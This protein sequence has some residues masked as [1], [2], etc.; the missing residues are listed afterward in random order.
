MTVDVS[1]TSAETYNL[2]NM[3]R[4]WIEGTSSSETSY[5]S[6]T[7]NNYNGANSWGTGGAANTTSDRYSTNL[8]NAGSTTFSALGSKTV[9][10]NSDGIQVIQGWI[11]GTVTNY[12]LTMQNYSTVSGSEYLEIA[13]TENTN[14]P[15]PKLNI[16]YCY[17]VIPTTI[18]IVAS[19]G[20]HGT[21]TPSGPLTLDYLDDQTY[22]INATT[23]GYHIADVLVDGTSVGPVST[24]TF[25][26]VE[27]DHTITAT[28]AID[29]FTLNYAAGTGGNLTGNISQV[30]DYNGSG[31]P[32]TAVP[33]TGYH[34]VNWSDGSTANPRT[35][36]NVTAN[37]SVT[38]NFA[39]NTYTLTYAAGAGGTLTGSTTQTV[40]YNGSGTAVTA[41]PNTGYHF[42]NWSDGSTANPRTDTNVTANR[43]RHRQLRYQHLH[44]QLC[45]RNRW[46]P[47]RKYLADRELRR[48]WLAVTAVPNT[49]YHFVSWSDGSTANP[50]TDTNVTANVN[51]TAN[52]AI[53]T[54]TLNYTAGTG[55][56]LTG[57]AS[58]NVNY[59][60]DGTP[61]TAV[62]S[63]GYH[64]VSWSDGS[65]DNPRTD[66]NITSDL[67][68]TANFAINTFTLNYTAGENGSLTGETSQIVNYGADGSQV[69]AVPEHRL[70][71]RQLVRRLHSQPPHGYQCHREY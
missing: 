40:N 8:W 37:R 56:S 26:N 65:T 70:P 63:T 48:E 33:N 71:L 7:W 53:D 12:G 19:A 35:D 39:I 51:V 18:S 66:E 50:R 20:E 67:N 34:F 11:E 22:T 6:A 61:V 69:T 49:G 55:G 32:V 68:V 45:R 13:S 59:G 23:T 5:S 42:V 52:F 62:P 57:D 28:F 29:T 46:Q 16:E 38:A 21:I 58:Q 24:Y 4:S 36:A 15:G 41:V 3:R 64:F 54:F 10:L 43:Q 17:T 9:D 31:T 25:D 27:E 60:A 44:P 2:Y 47:D 14:K 30:V 1:H